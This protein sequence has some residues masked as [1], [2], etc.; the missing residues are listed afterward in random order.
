MWVNRWN[1][2]RVRCGFPAIVF[3]CEMFSLGHWSIDL[4][5]SNQGVFFS[6]EMAQISTL[7]AGGGFM[8]YVGS[9]NVSPVMHFQ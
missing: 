9:N 4:K 7:L 2:H 5:L 6:S 8:F 1:Q 3:E